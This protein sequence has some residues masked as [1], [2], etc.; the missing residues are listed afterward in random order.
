MSSPRA[1]RRPA[2]RGDDV[3]SMLQATLDRE[4][5]RRIRLRRVGLSTGALALVIVIAG[6]VLVQGNASAA[7][8]VEAARNTA[9]TSSALV[10]TT[11]LPTAQPQLEAK[12]AT[13]N[14][15]VKSK[16]LS[17][18]QKPRRT[19]PPVNK[20]AAAK[21]AS[22]KPRTQQLRIAIGS[23]GYEPSVI[24]AK[25]GQ[26]IVLSVGRGEGCAAGFLIPELGVEKDNSGGPVTI[27]LGNV[28]AGR[29]RFSC[30]MDMVSGTLIVK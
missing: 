11:A 15:P 23:Q 25:S 14:A 29:Y 3:I 28:P 5:H 10:T 1:C 16:P 2:L 4:E 9:P 18:E 12:A 20:L 6:A 24:R 13:P 27:N 17:A 19:K 8:R 26:P 21:P 30:G 7:D 22:S